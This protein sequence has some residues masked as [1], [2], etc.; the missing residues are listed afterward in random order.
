VTNARI[1]ATSLD[2]S[3]A[4]VDPPVGQAVSLQFS[5]PAAG[6]PPHFGAWFTVTG[7][8]PGLTRIEFLGLGVLNPPVADPS[9]GLVPL[10]NNPSNDTVVWV[11]CRFKVSLG[12]AWIIPGRDLSHDA[13]F[14]LPDVVLTPD[15]A[16]NFQVDATVPNEVARGGSSLCPGSS[17]VNSSKAHFQGTVVDGVLHVNVTFDAVPTS[18]S[19]GCM[20][21]SLTSTARP[22]PLSFTQDI[23]SGARHYFF[24]LPHILQ[25]K[26]GPISGYTLVYLDVLSP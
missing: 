9:S 20:G 18:G 22:D 12:A 3:V 21:K 16:A 7:I 2:T 19:E 24:Q 4:T 13:S 17:S 23:S 11:H 10:R 6:R 15:N 25:E 1:S 8:T 14:Y 5:G 26:A